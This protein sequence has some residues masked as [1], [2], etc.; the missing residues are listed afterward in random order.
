LFVDVMRK[1]VVGFV[2]VLLLGAPVLACLAPDEPLSPA[3][4]ECCKEMA[5]ECGRADM[6]ASHSCCKPVVRPQHALISKTDF[7]AALHP[8]VVFELPSGHVAAAN[9][10]SAPWFLLADVHGPPESPSTLLSV[11]RI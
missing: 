5:D 9:P 6:P 11:L 2:C 4:K 7:F 10:P 1:S 8:A 3:E